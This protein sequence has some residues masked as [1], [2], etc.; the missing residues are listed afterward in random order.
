[1]RRYEAELESHQPM[2]V[3]TTANTAIR[4]LTTTEERVRN[5]EESR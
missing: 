5:T 1:M 2:T 4:Q 3:T